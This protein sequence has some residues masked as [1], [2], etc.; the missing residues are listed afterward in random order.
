MP[1]HQ[2]EIVKN[3]REYIQK[4]SLSS[5]DKA[6]LEFELT[7]KNEDI[8]SDKSSLFEYESLLSAIN[9]EHVSTS[10]YSGFRLLED[11]ALSMI[12]EKEL[13]LRLKSNNS[14]YERIDRCI[15]FGNIEEEFEKCLDSGLIQDLVK[16]QKEPDTWDKG[17]TYN[18]I[19]KS[20]E[21]K[22]EA[23]NTPF[24]EVVHEIYAES[25]STYSFVEN[26]SYFIRSDGITASKQRK[27]N[28]VIFNADK[29]EG[30]EL[31]L[32]FNRPVKSDKILCCLLY[33]SRCV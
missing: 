26:D 25:P 27:K 19:E 32:T 30:I 6:V 18:R 7:R 33:T 13:S 11:T 21:K 8:F 5:A 29:K 15:R 22:K 23:K 31:K 17:L 3:I 14:W 4:S 10:C 28:V 2:D 16:R 20:I 9:Q 1:F 24:E 12:S